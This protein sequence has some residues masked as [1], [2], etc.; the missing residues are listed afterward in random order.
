MTFQGHPIIEPQAQEI[1]RIPRQHL[2]THCHVLHSINHCSIWRLFYLSWSRI[3][4]GKEGTCDTV[5][6]Y[7][8]YIIYI[9]FVSVQSSENPWDFLSEKSVNDVFCYIN[10]GMFGKHLRSGQSRGWGW[11]LL[12]QSENQP[13]VWRAGTKC[14]PPGRWKGKRSWSMHQW[15][16]DN[17]FINNTYVMKSS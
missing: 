9:V 1:L 17:D 8:I 12:Y 13:C 2:K 4:L 10:E 7:Y 6:L 15:P 3:F 16:T 14:P 5:V 11:G